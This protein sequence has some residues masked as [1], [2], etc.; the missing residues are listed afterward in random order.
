MKQLTGSAQTQTFSKGQVCGKLHSISYRQ[1][2]PGLDL[3]K[4]D[5]GEHVTLRG[6]ANSPSPDEQHTCEP[7]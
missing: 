3:L 1:K 5:T 4:E 6:G 2:M 7:G